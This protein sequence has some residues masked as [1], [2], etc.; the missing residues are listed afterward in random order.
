MDPSADVQRQ[1][2]QLIVLHI[3]LGQ[4]LSAR[5]DSVRNFVNPVV[6]HVYRLGENDISIYGVIV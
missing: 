1:G 3:K 6:F 5:E 4:V 2:C